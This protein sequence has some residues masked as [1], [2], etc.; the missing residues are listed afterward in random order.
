MQQ[1]QGLAACQPHPHLQEAECQE[2]WARLQGQEQLGKEA[3]IALLEQEAKKQHEG[4]ACL[5]EE[6][7]E[8][9]A[10]C[11]AREAHPLEAG[12]LGLSDL[13]KQ[14]TFHIQLS[15]TL[16]TRSRRSTVPQFTAS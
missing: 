7:H 13:R 9:E 4:R 3:E 2:A 14:V 10:A 6:A 5:A 8:A 1:V 12:T 15:Q 16:S 11:L